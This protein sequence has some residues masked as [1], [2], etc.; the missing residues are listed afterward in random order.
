MG[1]E[2]NMHEAIDISLVVPLYNKELSIAKTMESVLAQ[3]Y[4]PT[5][6]LI[7]DDGST[8]NSVIIVQ[9]FITRNKLHET[10]L[11]IRKANGGVCSARNEGMRLAKY[12]YIAF[13]D[14]DDTWC[15]E[16]LA[17]QAGMIQDFPEAAMWG[18]N[19]IERKKGKDTLLD[20]GLSKDFR[21][22]IDNY[23]TK[24]C[25]SDLFWSST[26]V[27]RKEV[28]KRIGA[29]DERIRYSEDL[30]MWYRI[31]LNYRVA[32]YAKPFAVYEQDADNRAMERRV[33]LKDFLPYYVEKYETYCMKNKEFAHFIH[34]F[35]AAHIL[36]YYF[37]DEKER[38]D[39]RKAV[40][41]LRYQDIHWK[42]SLFYRLPY[43]IGKIFYKWML[44]RQKK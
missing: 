29:F 31:I 43:P 6:V 5:E 11:I 25:T 4:Q 13:L 34:T 16:Y 37:G 3:T 24:N 32:F 1:L 38:K 21:G 19:W 39:A 33:R 42:Y 14:A 20:T 8:D 23:W 35:A 17:T 40:K 7:V 36:C 9:D 44:I 2:K 12:N 30:D 26:V 18:L 28:F 10:W 22:Y 27:I 15:P 41:K